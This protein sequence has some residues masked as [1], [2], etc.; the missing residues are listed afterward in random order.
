M[1]THPH[2]FTHTYS[3]NLKE[4]DGGRSEVA[5]H[6]ARAAMAKAANLQQRIGDKASRAQDEARQRQQQQQL[7]EEKLLKAEAKKD[8]KVERKRLGTMRKMQ[9]QGRTSVLPESNSLSP[10]SSPA[11]PTTSSGAAHGPNTHSTSNP[12]PPPKADEPGVQQPQVNAEELEKAIEEL[13]SDATLG[14]GRA[15]VTFKVFDLGGQSTFYI[16]HPFFLTRFVP[17][18][19]FVCVCLRVCLCL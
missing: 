4:T 6:L 9:K 15:Q 5:S 18:C 12:L 7:E 14:D 16:F 17:V 13:A 2:I 1:H 3:P 11:R 19:L 8:M 10:S